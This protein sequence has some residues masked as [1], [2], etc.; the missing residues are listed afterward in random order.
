M[1]ALGSAYFTLAPCNLT[2]WKEHI[3]E[4]RNAR[5]LISAPRITQSCIWP[6]N[7]RVLVDLLSGKIV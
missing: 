3:K 1:L 6:M 5:Y 7:C 4:K 2:T